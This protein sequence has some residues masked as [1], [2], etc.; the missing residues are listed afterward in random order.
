M[1]DEQLSNKRREYY[2]VNDLEELSAW[3]AGHMPQLQTLSLFVSYCPQL[4]LMRQLAHLELRA[5]EFEHLNGSLQ[6][7]L[8]LQ[9]A[10][11]ACMR[12]EAVLDILDVSGLAGLEQLSLQDVYPEVLLIPAG[13]RLDL[14]GEAHTMQQVLSDP[15]VVHLLDGISTRTD[16]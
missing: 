10:L 1:I 13:C 11:L 2:P 16:S 14:Q 3:L 5:I 8:S 9:T 7:M 15:C 4:P 12:M 6:Q